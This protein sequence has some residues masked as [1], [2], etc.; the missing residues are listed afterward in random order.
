MMPRFRRLELDGV[1]EVIPDKHIDERGFFSEVWNKSIWSEAGIDVAFV[2][3]NHS[4]SEKPGTLRGLHYQLPPFGQ[5]KLVRVIQGSVFDVAVDIRKSSSSFGKW[6]G[7]E[8]SAMKWNQLFIP[9]GF[10]HGFLTLEPNTQV[11]YKVSGRYSSVHDRAIRFD[12]P[13]IGINWP[14][15]LASVVLSLRD[16]NAPL[17]AAAENGFA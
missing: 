10:A 16:R 13:E 9:E 12:D 15:D 1:I 5:A 7:V 4:V 11:L 17:L 6:V 2:Q 14:V 3:D 8:I